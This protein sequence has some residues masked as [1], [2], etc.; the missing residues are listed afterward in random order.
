MLVALHWTRMVERQRE[1]TW[2]VRV[3]EQENEMLQALAEHQ[4]LSVSDVLRQLVRRAY[5]QAF[6]KSKR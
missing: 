3:T 4:G 6:P 1:K 2:N 5:A